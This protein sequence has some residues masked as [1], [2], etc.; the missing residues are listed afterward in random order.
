MQVGD[1]HDGGFHAGFTQLAEPVDVVVNGPSGEWTQQGFDVHAHGRSFGLKFLLG[2]IDECRRQM[3]NF[4]LCPIT[5]DGLT[6]SI[7][8]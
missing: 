1:R 8:H 7:K 3:G 4:D 6:V 2:R 5:P